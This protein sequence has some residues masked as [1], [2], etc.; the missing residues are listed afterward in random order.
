MM[1]WKYTR[2][3]FL[4]IV[5][6]GTLWVLGKGVLVSSPKQQS[7]SAVFPDQVSLSGWQFLESKPQVDPIGRTYEYMQGETQLTIEMRYV[8]GLPSNEKPFREYDPTIIIPAT[9]Q[10]ISP[11]MRQQ[12]GG[13]YGLYI[14]DGKAYLRSCINPRGKAVITYGQFIHNRYTVDLQPSRLIPWL[15]AQEPLR[16]YRCLWAYLSMPLMDTSPDAAYQILEKNWTT[17]YKWWHSN[18]PNQ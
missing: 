18:F 6:G 16:D 17:W 10:Q 8:A 5:L 12:D 11:M 2:I 4:M 3:P 7:T 15:T 14:Q 13:Y 9:P 1:F